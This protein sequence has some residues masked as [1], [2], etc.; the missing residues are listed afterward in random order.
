[1]TDRL[2]TFDQ[3]EEIIRLL[4]SG[5]DGVD[6]EVSLHD[7][8][9]MNR[10]TEL[11]ASI[12]EHLGET[13]KMPRTDVLGPGQVQCYRDDPRYCAQVRLGESHHPHRYEYRLTDGDKGN[14]VCDGT[15]G[16]PWP[17]RPA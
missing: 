12:D 4:R 17:E 6:V 7:S 1:M 15:A 16:E 14:Y 5:F 8:D 3:G 9:A 2:M 10:I 13:A 11:V